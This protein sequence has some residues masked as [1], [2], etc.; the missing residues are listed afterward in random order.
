MSN[1]K[2]SIENENQPSCLGAVSGRFSLK[3]WEEDM[4]RNDM[5]KSEKL[6]RLLESREFQL[7][8]VQ[9]FG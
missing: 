6:I 9:L 8:Y 5:K 2:T 4:I 7:E 1:E 3:F